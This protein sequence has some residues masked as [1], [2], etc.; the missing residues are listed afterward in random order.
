MRSFA[1]SRVFNSKLKNMQILVYV[2]K[3]L[4]FRF[5][6]LI[7]LFYQTFNKKFQFLEVP[8]PAINILILL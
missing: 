1:L 8:K 3:Y 5:F 7:L 6:Y 4:G 2:K